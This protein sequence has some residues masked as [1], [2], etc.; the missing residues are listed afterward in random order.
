MKVHPLVNLKESQRMVGFLRSTALGNA[1]RES[2]ER[3]P[4]EVRE[5]KIQQHAARVEALGLAGNGVS[6]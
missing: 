2:R 4:A 5:Q 3:G 1:Y 6:W